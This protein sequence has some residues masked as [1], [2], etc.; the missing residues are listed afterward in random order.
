[1][2]IPINMRDAS[3]RSL[4]AMN[5]MSSVFLD[6]RGG[7][8]DSDAQLLHGI[9]GEMQII[10]KHDLRY[11]FLFILWLMQWIS[12]ALKRSV[13]QDTCKTS[14]IFSNL[15]KVFGRCKLPRM[16]G[17]LPVG[18]LELIEING[19]PPVRLH[20]LPNLCQCGAASTGINPSP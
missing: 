20:S 9:H 8:A 13:N 10:K 5:Y 12:G 16:G 2:M 14:A 3:H 15:D 11:A 1:M 19:L 18:D 6:R 17:R 4:P 7:E